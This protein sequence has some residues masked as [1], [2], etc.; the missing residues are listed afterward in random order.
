MVWCYNGMGLFYSHTPLIT[1]G[2][3]WVAQHQ[4]AK[5]NTRHI[6]LQMGTV[7]PTPTFF[8]LLYVWNYNEPLCFFLFIIN[9]VFQNIVH[10][11]KDRR[12]FT[13]R[14]TFWI[15]TD[16][17]PRKWNLKLEGY[18]FPVFPIIKLHKMVNLDWWYG[19]AGQRLFRLSTPWVWLTAG[20]PT[21]HPFGKENDLNHTSIRT[22]SSR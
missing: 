18:G 4:K 2:S 16:S 17:Y 20:S 1:L 19:V 8:G 5:V 14:A 6:N 13:L 22:F 3:K 10:W 9:R 11:F 15:V 12:L 7:Q 21:N